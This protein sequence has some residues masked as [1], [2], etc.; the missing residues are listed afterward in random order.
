MYK[1][2]IKQFLKDKKKNKIKKGKCL[3]SVYDSLKA[4]TVDYKQIAIDSPPWGGDRYTYG[5]T[6]E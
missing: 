5:Q 1:I 6:K 3:N 2:L 4:F